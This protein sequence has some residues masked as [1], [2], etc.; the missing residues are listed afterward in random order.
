M[1]NF[2]FF[3]LSFRRLERLVESYIFLIL[4]TIP[5]IVS[6]FGSAVLSTEDTVFGR[7]LSR[8]IKDDN[9]VM[10]TYDSGA[11][12]HYISEKTEL[13]QAYQSYAHLPNASKWQTEI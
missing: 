1:V 8:V 11:D 6:P 12:G 2:V 3:G 10:L 4:L 5:S 9:V 7:F 13:Q